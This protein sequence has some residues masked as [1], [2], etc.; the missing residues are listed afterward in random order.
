[1]DEPL[2]EYLENP[3][4]SLIDRDD[5]TFGDIWEWI[6]VRLEDP[7][8]KMFVRRETLLT[9]ADACGGER[10]NNYHHYF[11]DKLV[12]M[13]NSK[14]AS[15]WS[16]EI[17]RNLPKCPER[18][19][20]YPWKDSENMWLFERF[21]HGKSSKSDVND[22]LFF[23]HRQDPTTFPHNADLLLK[24]SDVVFDEEDLEVCRDQFSIQFTAK[25]CYR[26]FIDQMK[27]IGRCPALMCVLCLFF[28]PFLTH[29]ET[30]VFIGKK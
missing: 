9:I 23:R 4:L 6:N 18:S 2:V 20:V 14:R 13:V 24:W 3:Y 11:N 30:H 8:F 22:S 17:P 28:F 29:V 15:K 5:K 1:M 27:L 12:T 16:D 25:G 26:G 7:F 10:R 21:L 19:N